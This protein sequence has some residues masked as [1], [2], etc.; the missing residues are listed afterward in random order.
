MLGIFDIE[1]F[2][3]QGIYL[4]MDASY[5]DISSRRIRVSGDFPRSARR[6]S[7]WRPDKV[8]STYLEHINLENSPFGVRLCANGTV[9]TKIKTCNAHCGGEVVFSEC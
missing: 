7:Q 3:Y 5:A 1:S 8:G 9:G 2:S 4:P 6:R